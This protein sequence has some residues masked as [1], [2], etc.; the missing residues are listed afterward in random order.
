[1]KEANGTAAKKEEKEQ[2][3]LEDDAYLL[4][5]RKTRSS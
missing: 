4:R 3:E 2:Q 1:M 5:C